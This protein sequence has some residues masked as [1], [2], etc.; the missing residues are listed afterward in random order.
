VGQFPVSEN[1]VFQDI[2]LACH[3]SAN[4]GE[5]ECDERYDVISETMHKDWKNILSFAVLG[6]A[7]AALSYGY[8]ALHDYSKPMNGIDFALL[9]TSMIFCP[10]QLLFAFCIDCEVIGWNGFAV[11]SAIAVLNVALYAVVGTLVFGLREKSAKA[12]NLTLR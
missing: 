9:A 12:R 10:P 6:L 2:A 5:S 1:P 4:F 8:A 11:Y 7:I 3:A